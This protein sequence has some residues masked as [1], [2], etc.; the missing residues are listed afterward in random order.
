[1]PISTDSIDDAVDLIDYHLDNLENL[2]ASLITDDDFKDYA[3]S[4]WAAIRS[5]KTEKQNYLHVKRR[6]ENV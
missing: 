4:V 3:D 5:M 2:H 1:M 6:I